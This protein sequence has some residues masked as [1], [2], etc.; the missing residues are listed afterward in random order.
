MLLN[1]VKLIIRHLWR[2]KGYSILNFA[3]LAPG[4]SACLLAFIFVRSEQS[5]DT[6]YSNNIYRLYTRQTANH[7]LEQE[8]IAKTMFPAGPAIQQEIPGIESQIRITAWHKIPLQKTDRKGT[9][10]TVFSADSNFLSFFDLPLT[11][12]DVNTALS[13]P[14]SI[15]LTESLAKKIFNDQNPIGE[16][17]VHEGRDT[18]YFQVTGILPELSVQSHSVQF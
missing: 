17:L 13:R 16:R 15:V 5:Y 7:S 4:M 9:M 12:G 3:G 14:G 8:N 18:Q 6:Q 10:A 1:H 11:S 2:H